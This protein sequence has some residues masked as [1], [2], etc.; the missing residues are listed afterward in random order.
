MIILS[1]FQLEN[2][3]SD[4]NIKILMACK[5]QCERDTH[6]HI[7]IMIRA[8]LGMNARMACHSRIKCH[9]YF[10]IRSDSVLFRPLFLHI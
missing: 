9:V 1:I 2:L 6:Q 10:L 7:I 8:V 4:I 3:L 5:T